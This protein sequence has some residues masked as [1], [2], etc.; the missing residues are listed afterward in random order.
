MLLKR[1]DYANFMRSVAFEDARV[2]VSTG[3]SA[4]GQHTWFMC[5]AAHTTNNGAVSA[6]HNWCF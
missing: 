2:P 1:L 3:T 4:S 5:P 6:A